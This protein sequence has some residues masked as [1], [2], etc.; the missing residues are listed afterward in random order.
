MSKL[1]IFCFA[2]VLS[3]F[4]NAQNNAPLDPVKW[5]YV[6]QKTADGEYNLLITAIIEKNG[7]F[8]LNIYLQM[9]VLSL[10]LFI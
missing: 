10:L 1:L 9:M 5:F 3:F 6:A 2:S 8:T 4:S 7:T